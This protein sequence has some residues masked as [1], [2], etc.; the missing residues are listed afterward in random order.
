MLAEVYSALGFLS[1]IGYHIRLS[2][3]SSKT[4]AAYNSQEETHWNL[5]LHT[6]Q[7]LQAEAKSINQ[8]ICKSYFI[9]WASVSRED[10]FLEAVQ[11]LV[12]ILLLPDTNSGQNQMIQTIKIDQSR[13]SPPFFTFVLQ[14]RWLCSAVVWW[15]GSELEN[16]GRSLQGSTGVGS[17]SDRTCL[18]SKNHPPTHPLAWIYYFFLNSRIARVVLHASF[19]FPI[20]ELGR[21]SSE[22][23]GAAEDQEDAVRRPGPCQ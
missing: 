9:P 20:R 3:P 10:S 8:A 4:S 16:V 23:P 14:H 2:F 15:S 1:E 22:Q 6:R 7:V 19:C 18:E 12:S 13:M 5:T 17:I 11:R 21:F